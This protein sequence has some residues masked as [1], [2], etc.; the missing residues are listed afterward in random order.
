[1]TT[2][3][4]TTTPSVR[5]PFSSRRAMRIQHDKDTQTLLEEL[6][7][8]RLDDASIRL[9]SFLEVHKVDA[10]HL[11]VLQVLRESTER[12]PYQRKL[13][14]IC[15]VTEELPIDHHV[16][17]ADV[18]AA[19]AIT[20]NNLELWGLALILRPKTP[21]LSKAFAPLLVRGIDPIA[22]LKSVAGTGAAPL[23]QIEDW[24]RALLF[25]EAQPD[26]TTLKALV[27]NSEWKMVAET[28]T[29]TN[30]STLTPLERFT[31]CL[32]SADALTEE[33]YMLSEYRL[34]GWLESAWPV[35][36]KCCPHRLSGSA[37]E[38]LCGIHWKL[39]GANDASDGTL[40]IDP[41]WSNP[42]IERIF[43]KFLGTKTSDGIELDLCLNVA[44]TLCSSPKGIPKMKER[45]RA[46]M[47]MCNLETN[48]SVAGGA[49]EVT[50]HRI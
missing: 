8:G 27:V 32:L 33:D 35:W 21:H 11:A 46:S 12:E 29:A 18:L 16:K 26:M 39:W 31:L 49:I 41:R 38:G 24:W 6:E 15:K 17:L 20:S 22:S 7:R 25:A 2:E 14:W 50:R 45:L 48:V 23:S 36:H 42:P 43:N 28:V 5:S 10:I 4:K 30:L 34:N 13:D 3:T 40:V 44:G 1:M 19:D 47:E 37:M 9:A